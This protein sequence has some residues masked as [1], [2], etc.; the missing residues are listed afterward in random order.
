MPTSQRH[1]SDCI[2][3]LCGCELH[4]DIEDVVL[5]GWKGN[6]SQCVLIRE[7]K[8]PCALL[9]GSVSCGRVKQLEND[10]SHISA[11]LGVTLEESLV[12]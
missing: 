3:Y 9:L 2:P 1:T 10:C 12:S 11:P 5:P 7:L 6:S 8:I 4:K